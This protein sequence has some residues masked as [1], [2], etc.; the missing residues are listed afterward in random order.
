MPAALAEALP[1]AFKPPA[2]FLPSLRCH[3]GD[4]AITE[5]TNEKNTSPEGIISVQLVLLRLKGYGM[6]EKHRC[7]M[8]VYSYTM[9]KL[10]CQA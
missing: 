1:L 9:L 10:V 4:L 7:Q 5:S 3:A 6:A 8:Y 2:G